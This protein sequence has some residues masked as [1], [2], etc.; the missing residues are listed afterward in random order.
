MKD[1][2]LYRAR[3]SLCRQMASRDPDRSWQFL[4]QAERWEHLAATETSNH[5]NDL[6]LAVASQDANATRWETIAAV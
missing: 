6:A 5:F 3:A 1:A 2:S 4:A